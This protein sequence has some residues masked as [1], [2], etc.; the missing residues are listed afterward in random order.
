[1]ITNGPITDHIQQSKKD[2]ERSGAVKGIAILLAILV[3]G[4]GLSWGANAYRSGYFNEATRGVV[5]D[6]FFIQGVETTYNTRGGTRT[7][8]DGQCHSVTI[9]SEKGTETVCVREDDYVDLMKTDA[10]EYKV[11][12]KGWDIPLKVIESN[13]R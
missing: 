7:Y 3:A 2:K 5:V 13:R 12:P 8:F 10:V 1:M 4:A 6:K 11:S 9:K